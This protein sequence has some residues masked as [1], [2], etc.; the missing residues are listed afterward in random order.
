[1]PFAPWVLSRWPRPCLSLPAETRRGDETAVRES[2]QRVMA[3]LRAL[4]KSQSHRPRRAFSGVGGDG[5]GRTLPA[6]RS[7]IWP[8]TGRSEA[9]EAIVSSEFSWT[10]A[11][12]RSFAGSQDPI[13]KM[14]AT[15]RSFVLAAAEKGWKGPPFDPIE[16]ARLHGLS[17]R[18]NAAIP[19]ARVIPTGEALEIQYNPNRPRGRVNFSIA[20]EIAHTFFPD[21]AAAVRNRSKEQHDP[22]GWQL[23]MLCN[24]GAA[25]L[26]MPFGSFETHED[27]SIEVLMRMRRDF[28]V[29]AEAVL[30]RFAK[31]TASPVAAFAASRVPGR[32]SSH[33]IDYAIASSSWTNLTQFRGAT[34][35]DP[36]LPQCVAIGTTSKGEALWPNASE[37]IWIEA[38]ALPAYRSQDLPRVAGFFRP[39]ATEPRLPEI[40]YLNG[41][42][43]LFA[44]QTRAAILHIVNDRARRWGRFGFAGAL[45]SRYPDAYV[46]YE[47]WTLESP[48]DLRLGAVRL[49]ETVDNNYVVSLVAQRGYGPSKDPRLSYA[50][51]DASLAD[52]ADRL[53]ELRVKS[54]QL[55]RIG[56]GQARGNWA[57]VEG[58]IHEHLVADGFDVRVYDLP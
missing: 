52:A 22:S 20:H 54:I 45:K 14:E 39:A 23:E 24:V 2:S 37:P 30:I 10:N 48:A 12:V 16:F 51:L 7:S 13:R 25:E 58:L 32:T 9:E 38:V 1:M 57:V 31:L 47:T 50:A 29:S 28:Q 34:V 42:A 56:T 36:V 44:Q 18:P 8:F 21:C 11:S 17:V 35:D 6:I 27:P 49:V 4:V 15:A 5:C 26:L 3:A 53:T 19:D 46:D 55:P 41:D 40:L 43:T 33:R